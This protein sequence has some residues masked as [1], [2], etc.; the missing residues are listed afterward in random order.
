MPNN[1]NFSCIPKE[2]LIKLDEN[3]TAPII[4]YS[5]PRE[6]SFTA[7]GYIPLDVPYS[8]FKS[9][10]RQ[11]IE[12]DFWR[13]IYTLEAA[14]IENIL[15][16]E[17]RTAGALIHTKKTLELP[18]DKLEAI[19]NIKVAPIS[20]A[21]QAK[22]KMLR[23]VAELVEGEE[24]I[25][26]KGQLN[27]MKISDLAVL[28]KE[29]ELTPYPAV[30][31]NGQAVIK[32]IPRAKSL[33]PRI[34]LIE[35]YEIR[36]TYADYGAA[37]VVK[38][39]EFAP[40]EERTISVSS[41]KKSETTSAQSQNILDSFGE[42]SSNEMETLVE[43]ESSSNSTES[44]ESMKSS[45]IGGSISVGFGPIGGSVD[46]STSNST[47]A[48]SAREDAAR[49]LSTAL[50]KHV[51]KSSSS[52]EVEINDTT[53]STQTEGE[54][55]AVTRV[56]KNPNFKTMNLVFRQMEQEYATAIYLKDV[57]IG[58][59]NTKLGSAKKV[60]LAE[61]DSLLTKVLRNDECI[62]KVRCNILTQLMRVKDMKGEPNEFIEEV[63]EP[64]F[65]CQKREDGSTEIVEAKD[66]D[67][68]PIIRRYWRKKRA[69]LSDA[70]DYKDTVREGILK[71]PG[72]I[73]DVKKRILRT[74]GIVADVF[75]GHGEALDC[76]NQKLQDE[77]TKTEILKNQE[78]EIKNQ[79]E[80][81]K[82]DI[83]NAI[84]D[85]IERVEAYQKLFMEKCLSSETDSE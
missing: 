80:Q 44:T 45:E 36:S 18:K 8:C 79:Q 40:N 43:N 23:S 70:H 22:K 7:K 51:A 64:I 46:A 49:Q 67:D 10:Y 53:T 25:R 17:T 73:L 21:P 50:D 74:D 33:D 11:E 31:F 1:D 41:Y 12:N 47:T 77:A 37:K 20:D 85:P 71:V 13:N 15:R 63:E 26:V 35:E 27:P 66:E 16:S 68:N 65:V 34:F 5:I 62:D 83:V 29:K 19:S 81:L 82:I 69:L 30:N 59:A 3:G 54:E 55:S 61:L 4:K 60:K 9:K 14:K 2:P 48:N 57:Q 56:I 78:L 38:T 84:N 42:E 76:F 72:I 6:S 39:M 75:L 52:R 32:L 24:Y 58:F 28:I